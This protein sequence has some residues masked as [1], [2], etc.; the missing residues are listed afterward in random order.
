MS[1][2]EDMIAN[3]PDEE[4]QPDEL[5]P[6]ATQAPAAEQKPEPVADEDTFYKDP[7]IQAALVKFE[8]KILNT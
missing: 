6:I 3:A 1:A 5:E 4:D 2:F 8:A 7:L